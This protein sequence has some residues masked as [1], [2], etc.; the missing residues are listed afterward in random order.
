MRLRT[1]HPKARVL[2]VSLVAP[3]VSVLPVIS[4]NIV[5]PH[6]FVWW[7][8]RPQAIPKYLR[9]GPVEQGG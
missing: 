2:I 4:M 9:A 6:A 1:E 5:G 8:G 7:S 3:L